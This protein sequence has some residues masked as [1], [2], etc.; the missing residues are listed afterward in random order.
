MMKL[1]ERLLSGFGTIPPGWKSGIFGF[2]V[3]TVVML[4]EF[5]VPVPDWIDE[6]WMTKAAAIVA[7][8]LSLLLKKLRTNGN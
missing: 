5:G 1:I 2:L 4:N 3:A 8:A 6:S 7:I